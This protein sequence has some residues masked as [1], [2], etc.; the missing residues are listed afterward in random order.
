MS[1]L[2]TIIKKNENDKQVFNVFTP[3]P[4]TRNSQPATVF[5]LKGGT[6]YQKLSDDKQARR[7]IGKRF[8][9]FRDSIPM[10]RREMGELLNLSLNSI[11]NFETGH[12]LPKTDHIN[13]LCN[14][15]LLNPLWLIEGDG[16]MT[17]KKPDISANHEELYELIKFPVVKAIIF[18]RLHEAK[19]YAEIINKD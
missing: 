19:K 15:F 18:G 17:R 7:M 6:M 10:S 1:L 4:A 14:K 2:L 16:P 8:R 9:R 3:Q 12:I 11:A 5:F 13:R